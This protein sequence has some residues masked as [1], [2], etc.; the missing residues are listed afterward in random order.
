MSDERQAYI[1]KS[2]L[3]SF[4]NALFAERLELGS[5]E[6][7]LTINVNINQKNP[8]WSTVDVKAVHFIRGEEKNKSFDAST[9]PAYVQAALKKLVEYAKIPYSSDEKPI[10][11]W[12]IRGPKIVGGKMSNERITKGKLVV[13]RSKKGPFI[14]VVHWNNNYPHIPFYAGLNDENNVI[15]TVS[16]D[17]EKLYDYVCAS[18]IGWAEHISQLLAT[19]WSYYYNKALENARR[20]QGNGGGSY[21]GG[22][23]GG[24]YGGGNNNNGGGGYRGGNSGGYGG[25]NNSGGYQDTT[26]KSESSGDEFKF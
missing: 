26:H 21:S 22:N 11:T 2:A 12:E 18:A 5:R 24:G 4:S 7:F 20:N 3:D 9:K 17:P 13:G 6:P 23:S 10:T 19:E 25:N 15:P 1:P 14:S 16:D 8:Q